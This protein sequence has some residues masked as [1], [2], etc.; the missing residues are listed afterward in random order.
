[1][2]RE[3][4]AL[5]DVDVAEVASRQLQHVKKL[6]CEFRKVS[7]PVYVEQYKEQLASLGEQ[8]T[9]TQVPEVPD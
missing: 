8:D 1:M 7:T 4:V 9:Q 5:F 3:N 6:S 2:G